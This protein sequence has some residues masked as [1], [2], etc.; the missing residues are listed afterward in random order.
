MGSGSIRNVTSVVRFKVEQ[1]PGIGFMKNGSSANPGKC[2]ALL[3]LAMAAGNGGIIVETAIA[4]YTIQSL[5]I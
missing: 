4:S 1:S 3:V 2:T 5:S